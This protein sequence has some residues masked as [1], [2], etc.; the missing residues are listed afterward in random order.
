MKNILFRQI[1]PV[2][3]MMLS[4]CGCKKTDNIPPQLS[5]TQI[6]DY[7]LIQLTNDQPDVPVLFT[8]SDN[9]GIDSVRVSIVEKGTINIVGYSSAKTISESNTLSVPFPFPSVAPSGIYTIVVISVD[10]NGNSS[11]KSYDVNI[12]NNKTASSAPCV[13]E[14]LPVPADKNVM[15]RLTVPAQTNDEDVWMTGDWEGANGGNNWSGG[16]DG[17][18]QFKMTKIS[19]TCYYI[20]ATLTNDNVFKFTRGNWGKVQKDANGNDGKDFRYVNV[21]PNNNDFIYTTG[22]YIDVKV[23]NWADKV[24]LPKLIMPAGTVASGKMTVLVNVDNTDDNFHYFLVKKGGDLSDKSIPLIRVNTTTGSKSTRLAA[25][26]LKDTAISY[27]VVKDNAAQTGI[28]AYGYEQEIKWDGQTNPAVLYLNRYKNQGSEVAPINNLFLIGDATP[29]GWNNPVAVPSQQFT[30][31]G[32]GKFVI[33]RIRLNANGKILFLPVN[34]DWGKIWG[35]GYD[36][37]GTV[38][39]LRLGGPALDIITPKTAGDYKI[40]V[41]FYSGNYRLTKL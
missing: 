21:I 35:T 36:I 38:G 29:S 1:L 2:L 6:D 17:R 34:G 20:F 28:N 22:I 23:D 27:L 26:V 24:V 19:P 25:A 18:S 7:D 39:N 3:L 11:R 5:T 9:K 33:N 15:I 10:K 12:L 14:N 41:D 8:T 37:S 32:N 30:S 40:E 13:F 16:D 31:A 4:V